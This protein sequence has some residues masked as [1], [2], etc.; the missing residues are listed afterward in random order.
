MVTESRTLSEAERRQQI[1]TAARSVF[2]EKGYETAT[3][4]DIVQ[5]AGVAQGTFYLYFPSKKDVV[6][7]LARKP[8][9]LVA[10]ELHS[11]ADTVTSF[12]DM[13]RAMVKAG[14]AVA[15]EYPDLCL[16]V[17]MSDES[18]TEAKSTDAG[19]DIMSQGESTFE[20]A[21]TSGQLADVE[22]KIAFEMFH[23]ILT[24]AMKNA[25]AGQP[26]ERFD[27]IETAVADTVVR[28]FVK[29]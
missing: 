28:A 3:V 11:V 13:L 10:R 26:K 27:E 7:G 9:E 20:Q 24:G 25:C 18:M 1:L 5:R 6:V 15:G 14:F 16:L 4:S 22:P 8:M 2:E 29:S 23:S 12:E 19:R 21:V 17:H